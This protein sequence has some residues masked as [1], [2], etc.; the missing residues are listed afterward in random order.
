MGH[1]AFKVLDVRKLGFMQQLICYVDH[2][3]GVDRFALRFISI[4]EG[5]INAKKM[6]AS[7][8]IVNVSMRRLHI[9]SDKR[10]LLKYSL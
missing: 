2:F 6:L 9:S 7:L 5:F 8:H 3:S 10:F 4:L 1:P